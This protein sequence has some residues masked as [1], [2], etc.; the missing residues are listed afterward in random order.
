[1]DGQIL[2]TKRMMTYIELEENCQP[3]F[4]HLFSEEGSYKK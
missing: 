4:A 3:L 2:N 1:M